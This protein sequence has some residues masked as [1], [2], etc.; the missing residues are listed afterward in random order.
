MAIQEGERLP[1]VQLHIMESGKTTP[2]TTDELTENKRVVIFAVPGAF[3]PTCSIQHLPGYV[4]LADQIKAKGV[5]DIIC[6]S[7]NDVFVM[8][9]W[10]ID[11]GAEELKMVADG[12]GKLAKELGLV[13]DGSNFG[14]GIRSQRYA[15]IVDN[16]V[17]TKLAVEAP[18]QFEVSKA[19]RILE[20]L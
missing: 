14:M 10:G 1:S 16:G 3:T 4:Q 12:N 6:V 15:M 8:H 5:D 7:V 18:G 17:V 20:Q 11:S 2:V 19:E 13:M 9:A